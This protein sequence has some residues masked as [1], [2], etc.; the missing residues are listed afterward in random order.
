MVNINELKVPKT[1]II[2]EVSLIS[3]N[4]FQMFVIEIFI[5]FHSGI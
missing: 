2:D 4:Y 5:L 3:K 1:T